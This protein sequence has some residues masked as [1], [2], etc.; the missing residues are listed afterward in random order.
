[1]YINL[2]KKSKMINIR[3]WVSFYNFRLKLRLIEEARR[4]YG[5][6]A[7]AFFG[8]RQEGFGEGLCEQ[9][10]LVYPSSDEGHILKV[11]DEIYEFVPISDARL[12]LLEKGSIRPFY[13]PQM[14]LHSALS[15]DEGM[16]WRSYII[17]EAELGVK[18]LVYSMYFDRS[19]EFIV[20]ASVRL[21]RA[22]LLLAGVVPR[23]THMFHQLR[24]HSPSMLHKLSKL[25]GLDT[26]PMEKLDPSD[27][28]GGISE[29]QYELARRKLGKLME[30]REHLAAKVM[31]LDLISKVPVKDDR[32]PFTK[33]RFLPSQDS[34]EEW[35]SWIMGGFKEILEEIKKI[36]KH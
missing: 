32:N 28:K 3:V 13:D 4:R 26:A 35:T 1:M 17:S 7:L 12:I 5:E 23:P 22:R 15:G 34:P 20:R 8:C 21:A 10:I 31:L 24:Q 6:K 18:D 2:S 16:A 9:D 27:L 14:L 30:L 36:N 33:L 11:G 25:W 19:P 29:V